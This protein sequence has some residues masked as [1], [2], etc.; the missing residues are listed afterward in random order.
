LVAAHGRQADY[1]R[2]IEAGPA[3]RV[4]VNR[5]WRTGTATVLADDDPLARSRT[6]PYRWDAALGRLMAS[7][8]LTIRID[9]DP[10]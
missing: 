2:N 9:L 6:L 8:P 10:V 5:V 3:V 4:K 1:V 7:A